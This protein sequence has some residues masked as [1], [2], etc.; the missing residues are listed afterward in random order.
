M[1]DIFLNNFVYLGIVVKQKNIK[2]LNNISYIGNSKNSLKYKNKLTGE[3][4]YLSPTTK[5]I[6]TK[7]GLK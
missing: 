6:I 2:S 3:I 7:K 1:T 5:K 4:Y